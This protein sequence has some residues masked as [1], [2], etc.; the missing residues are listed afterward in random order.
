MRKQRQ[1]ERSRSRLILLDLE[2]HSPLRSSSSIFFEAC[3]KSHFR[4]STNRITP[5]FTLCVCINIIQLGRLIVLLSGAI[6][7]VDSTYAKILCSEFAGKHP[8]EQ[9]HNMWGANCRNKTFNRNK[10][11][12]CLYICSRCAGNTYH[13]VSVFLFFIHRIHSSHI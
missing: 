11:W 9:H 5:L 2:L 10:H 4:K 1:R 12:R 6:V 8:A 7:C 3:Q 13:F